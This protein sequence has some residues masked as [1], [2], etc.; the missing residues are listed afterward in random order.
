[1]LKK[2]D[3]VLSKGENAINGTLMLLGV[4]VLFINVL[5]R[6]IFHMAS[7]WVEE[8]LRYAIIWVTFFG[9]SQCAKNGLHVGIDILA[10]S[11]PENF[12]RFVMA[13]DQFI[14]SI[15]CGF[16]TYAG[17]Q[18]TGLVLTTMQKSPAILLPMWLVYISLP[19]GCAL[20][21]IRFFVAG[22]VVLQNKNSGTLTTDEQGNIDMSR[23]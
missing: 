19:L 14:A 12:K 13:L 11:L 22:I 4:V 6:Y 18:L 16:C 17:Y 20:M 21:T 10:Q 23:L 8:A 1:M 5:M 15:L 3:S 9:G 2:I 7:S